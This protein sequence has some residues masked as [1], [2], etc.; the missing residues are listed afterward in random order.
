MKLRSTAA[1][2]L[3][4]WSLMCPPS[5]HPCWPIGAVQE[6]L[7]IGGLCER[8]IAHRSAPESQWVES[9][10]YGSAEECNGQISPKSACKCEAND[11]STPQQMTPAAVATPVGFYLMTPPMVFDKGPRTD[12]PLSQW[13][14][15]WNLKDGQQR[16]PFP[17]LEACEAR[18]GAIRQ[19]YLE[20]S[21]QEAEKDADMSR[22]WAQFG[23]AY[24][25][26]QCVQV[27]DSRLN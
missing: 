24:A 5:Y 20:E 27:D 12:A 1:F 11:N 3:L 13:S 23:S 8:P 14:G 6:L 19:E 10:V 16:K 17:T 21:R 25:H 15:Q 7:G 9:G 22:L 2:A 26:A 18:K 4:G